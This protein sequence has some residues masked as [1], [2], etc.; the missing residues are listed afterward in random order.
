MYFNIL[1]KDLKRKRTMNIILLLFAILAS[2]FVSSG[3]NNVVTVLNGTEY[4]F[5]KAGVGDY[6]V[7]TQ[8]GD[9]G[10]RNLLDNSNNVSSYVSDKFLL[11]GKSA[12]L[13]HGNEIVSE[14]NANFLQGYSNEGIKFFTMDNKE[15]KGVK[16]GEIY[17]PVGFLEKNH[18]SLNDVI[19]VNCYG[20]NEKYKIA[21]EFKDALFGSE[22]MGNTR[23][24][25]SK[26]DYEKIE[27]N[28]N[29][30]SINDYTGYMFYINT[31]NQ[32]ELKKEISNV[33]NIL[34]D[35]NRD[36]LKLCYI[37][38][39]IIA[40]IVLVLSVVLCIVSFVLLKFVITFTIN[41]D[42]REIG[43]MKAIGVKNR[44]IRSI[45]IFKYLFISL[46]GGVIGFFVGIPFGNFLIKTVS[47]K[48][49][50]GQDFGILLN[51]VGVAIVIIIM[52]GFAY[53]FTAKIKKFSPVDAIRDGQVGERFSKK[54]K[55]N[56]SKSKL[57]NEIFI[58]INDVI[59]APKRFITIILSFIIC[60][61][62]VFGVVLVS[63]T[64]KSDRLIGTFGKKSDI[65]ITDSKFMKLE[66]MGKNGDKL[67]DESIA[68]IENDLEKLNMPGKVTMEVWYKYPLIIEGNAY[69]ATFQQNKR[70][71]TSDYDYLEGTA[72]ENEDEIAITEQISKEYDIKIGDT[73][74]IDFGI[75]KKECMVVGYFQ[76]MN[77]LG[78]VIRLHQNAPT[79]MEYASAMMSY[80]ID[81]KDKASEKE[82][83]KRINIL[84]NYYDIKDVFDAKGYCNDCMGVADTMDSIAKLLMLIT[85]IVVVLV[86]ILMERSFISNETSQIA[87][88]KA[89]G[90]KNSFII[91][92]QVYR[93]L[94]VTVISEFL[95][96]IFTYPVTKLWCDPIFKQM[97]ATDVK[98]LFKP[99]SLLIIY[100]GIILV[101]N[102][103]AVF[104]TALYINKITSKDVRNIE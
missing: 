41:E 47:E 31:N 8:K 17:V 35:G 89:V 30:E 38:E 49:V 40:L 68:D 83:N 60:L 29:I 66:L 10:M 48:M 102:I 63:D 37:M 73:V 32:K 16:S 1:K 61:L 88:L 4:Y 55:I 76:T 101:I 100:P 58:A 72:P 56:L 98:Y 80:Q 96:I 36:M 70:T 46:V 21:G 28:E 44:K 50:L 2:M 39:I 7:V 85:C 22:M 103:L 53:R 77:Q 24:I 19:E 84:K 69:S 64:M 33:P 104:L 94:I 54:T 18:V 91:K 92:W 71:K 13:V 62:F 6:I 11:L 67:L 52:T 42:I 51:V 20:I 14:N 95:A 9:N 25:I 23:M 93:F 27:N 26:D 90:F 65:Y 3:I 74:T 5:D 82:N 79:S 78:S 87:L 12:I 99:V 34:F 15:L 43:V 97:G 59:S 57:K 86:T 45:Y 81:F 75:E